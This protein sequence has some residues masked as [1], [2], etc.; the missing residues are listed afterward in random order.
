MAKK[1]AAVS[2]KN[3]CISLG[4]MTITEVSKDNIE[5]FNLIEVLKSWDGID[6]ISLT[7]K[8]DTDLLPLEE[9]E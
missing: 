2:F 7:I 5:E 3:A 8:Y 1:T 9:E 6:G 4:N